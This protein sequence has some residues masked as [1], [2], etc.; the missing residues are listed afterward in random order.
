MALSALRGEP[1]PGLAEM[2]DA[3]LAALCHGDETTL[4]VVERRLLLGERVG[5]IDEA[6]PQM[7][8][9]A[10][11]ERWQAKCRLKP[12]DL[13]REIALD[14]RTETG[15][16]KSTLLHRLALIGVDWGR[17]L[18][19]GNARGTFRETWLLAWSPILAVRLAEALVFGVTV[20]QAARNKTMA[21]CDELGDVAA[22]AELVRACL[23]ADLPE[24]ADRCIARLQAVAISSGD[25]AQLMQ[26]VPP[27][28][29]I[30]RYGTAR[31]IPQEQLA[32]LV[33]ALAA[34]I[35]AGTLAA[36][37]QI[38]PA[39]AQVLRQAM[40]GYD[41]TLNL[42]GDAHLLEMWQRE[43]AF[44]ADD[45]LAAPGPK[46]PARR[47]RSSGSRRRSRAR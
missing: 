13:E 4:R 2:H 35:N 37:R 44:V 28:V 40:A 18:D 39:E 30:L 8:L 11:L 42:H 15:L 27:L 16:L 10:D 12:E 24:A 33:S 41:A 20:E 43:L 38:E 7:P 6:V 23:L 1:A 5:A 47:G 9:A 22:L 14:L 34:E 36:S 25:I 19:A 45:A 31:P 3:T 29:A 21:R 17:L 26:A 46:R 32:N